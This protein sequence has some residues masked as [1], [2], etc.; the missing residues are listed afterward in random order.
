MLEELLRQ[1]TSFNFVENIEES[2]SFNS[3]Q[4][5]LNPQNNILI[6]LT[7]RQLDITIEE[8]ISEYNKFKIAKIVKKQ[9]AY[10]FLFILCILDHPLSQE[11]TPRI[12]LEDDLLINPTAASNLE[13]DNNINN[14]HKKKML[15]Q[16]KYD[17][18]IF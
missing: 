2:R 9:N 10:L 15:I 6:P 12:N 11:V 14:S 16:P 13:K 3:P 17:I 18:S 8:E 1:L 4:K 7:N 5:S